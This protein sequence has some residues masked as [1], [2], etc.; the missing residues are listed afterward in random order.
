MIR[1]ADCERPADL[2]AGHP[3]ARCCWPL[4]SRDRGRELP[5]SGRAPLPMD[6]P[7]I[8]HGGKDAADVVQTP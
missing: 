5:P 6:A 2:Y 7:T 3:A 1:C 4:P 8:R